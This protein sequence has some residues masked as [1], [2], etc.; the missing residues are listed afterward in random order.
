MEEGLFQ[1][2]EAQLE[3][4]KACGSRRFLLLCKS[5]LAALHSE[6]LR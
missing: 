6:H 4:M 1:G 3:G 2:C 5:L